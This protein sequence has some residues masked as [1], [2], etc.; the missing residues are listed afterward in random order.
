[1]APILGPDGQAMAAHRWH[2][3]ESIADDDG[4][5]Y[6]GIEGVNQIVRFDYG[7]D[8][9]FARGHPIPVPAGIRTL[10]KIKASRHWSLCHEASRLA[11]T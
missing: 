1:M 2:D 9:L 7:K 8:G 11:A 4:T 5:L 10:P 3:T 6:V